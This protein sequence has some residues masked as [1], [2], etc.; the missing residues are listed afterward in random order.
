MLCKYYLMVGSSIVDIGNQD[1]CMDASNMITNLSDIQASYARSGL[2]GVVRKCGS[3]I[4]FAFAAREA[5]IKEYR[6]NYLKS[7][8]AFAIYAIT[9]NWTYIKAWECPL[10]FSSFNW[11]THLAYITCLDNSAAAIIKANKSTQYEYP[12]AELKELSQLN[13]DGVKVRNEATFELC[14]NSVEGQSYSTSEVF[15][16][17][18][19]I[20]IPPFNKITDKLSINNAILMHNQVEDLTAPLI[21]YPGG[22]IGSG[23][24]SNT[25]SYFLECLQDCVVSLDFT[26]IKIWGYNA[27]M[28]NGPYDLGLIFLLFKIPTSGWPELIFNQIPTLRGTEHTYHCELSGNISL[29]KGEKLQLG[30]MRFSLIGATG[31]GTTTFYMPNDSGLAAW[32]GVAEPMKVDVVTPKTLL[33][34]ILESMSGSIEVRGEIKETVFDQENNRLK[35]TLLVASESIRDMK[36]AK[37]Y[38]SFNKFCDFMEAEFGYVYVIS[39][40]EPSA[41]GIR[42]EVLKEYLEFEGFFVTDDALGGFTVPSGLSY[43]IK[44]NN[45]ENYKGAFCALASDGKYY[46]TWPGSDKYQEYGDW[47]TTSLKIDTNFRDKTTGIYY[48]SKEEAIKI[49]HEYVLDKISIK[50]FDAISHFGGF[51][52]SVIFLSDTYTGH[53]EA[54]NIVYASAFAKFLYKDGNAYYPVFEGA[55]SYNTADGPRKDVLFVDINDLELHEDGQVYVV[56]NNT[57]LVKYKGEVPTLVKVDEASLVTFKHRSEVFKNQVIKRIQ[58]FTEPKYTVA[59]DRIHSELQ[60]G[61]EKQDYD[62]GNNGYDEFNFTN[63]YATGITIKGSTLR[64]ICPYR[65]DCYGFEELAEKRGAETSSTDTD[66]HVFLVNVLPNKSDGKYVIDRTLRVDGAYTETVFNAAY[67]PVFMIEANKGYIG[68]FTQRLRFASSDGNSSIAIDRKKVSSDV[69]MNGRMFTSGDITIQTN[70]IELPEDWEGIIQFEWEG[71][72][73]QGFLK[74]VDTNFHRNE[75]FEYE[76]IEKEQICLQ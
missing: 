41:P 72:V 31:I 63:Y 11:D 55:E 51:E 61:Y 2:G 6:S 16:A 37:I 71:Y 21:L 32:N 9:N 68:M 40:C 59:G 28:T 18:Y 1:N 23:S 49:L 46:T 73:F 10:D 70:D 12:V 66:A 19:S 75:A 38:S 44:Y 13:Y 29:S 4:S 43:Q 33:N 3:T 67:A 57:S 30:I 52:R 7:Q 25:T 50:E 48:Y 60:I 34:K 69:K 42:D 39:P 74:S 65:A 36:D 47:F 20:W 26:N 22:W 45:P 35:N 62:N 76:L 53:V 5:L 24:N 15:G 56:V 27:G 17:N 8:A 14:G 54:S 58:L 64:L